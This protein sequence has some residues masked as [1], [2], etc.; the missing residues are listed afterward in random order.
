MSHEIASTTIET[1]RLKT[2][3]RT[4]G[5]DGPTIVLL[6]GNVSSGVFWE[7]TMLALA[8]VARTVAPDMRG[9]GDSEAKPIDATRGMRDI[10]DDLH[11]LFEAMQLVGDGRKVHLVGWSVGGNAIV[12]YAIDH[13]DTLHSLTLINP[14]SPFGFGGTKGLEGRPCHPDFAGSGGG[15][16]NPDFVKAMTEGDRGDASPTS[17]RNVMN[18]FYWKPPFRPQPE[19]EELFVSSMLATTVGDGNYPGTM[20]SS[21]NWPGVAPGDSGMNNA[22]APKYCNQSGFADIDPRP[23]V[24]W[25][26]GADDQIVSDR[27]MFDFGVLGELGLVPGWPG[28]EVFPA[29]PMVGQMRHMLDAYA[30]AG[31]TYKEV[32]IENC[33]HSP[34]LE[35]PD[36]FRN[37]LKQFVGLT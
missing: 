16:A 27:S 20:S 18:A 33:G 37:A 6:H 13:A 29:Q 21:T 9:Y 14:G 4:A 22:I 35:H 30:R 26:R 25:I 2:H 19:R 5:S 31:G 23:P 7:E 28:A 36:K 24:L 34:H 12:Q 32:V 17:P 11:A 1:R 3:V 10:A 15:T 8:P